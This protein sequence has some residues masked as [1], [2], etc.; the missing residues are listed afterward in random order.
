MKNKIVLS[1][2]FFSSFVTISFSQGCLIADYE[3]EGNTLDQSGN[4][5][6][7]V[8]NDPELTEDR[9]GNP[10]SAYLF[11]GIDDQIIIND[12]QAIISTSDFTITT[13]IKVNGDGGGQ[14]MNNP[15]F[16]QR[17]N[18]AVVGSTSS[19][20][21]LFA[22]YFGQ[23][24]FMLRTSH[25]IQSSPI[26]VQ[27]PKL[28]PNNW[29]FYAAIKDGNEMILYVDSIEVN[30]VTFDEDEVFDQSIDYVEIGSHT[31]SG[32]VRSYFN[33]VIDNLKIFDCA[34]DNAEILNLYYEGVEM[35]T[36][37][38]SCINFLELY[39]NPTSEEVTLTLPEDK[40]VQVQIFNIL[41]QEV[42]PEV[43]LVSD[44]LDFSNLPQATYLIYLT[45]DDESK[46]IKLVKVE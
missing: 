28:E 21:G 23:L 30:R 13:W 31:Y 14:Y 25:P 1:L 16:L 26:L 22:D 17:D 42:R 19:L 44:K 39:P 5:F 43:D 46:I 4:D 40:I 33:G 35:P 32:S 24:T 2:I 15:I 12:N 34:L 29:H 7:G 36:P 20:V 8:G 10:M 38:E 11:D 6:H 3:F 37:V 45:C 41:G 27:H 18:S 9:L